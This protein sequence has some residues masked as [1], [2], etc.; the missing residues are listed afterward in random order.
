[1]AGEIGRWRNIYWHPITGMAVVVAAGAIVYSVAGDVT[2]M[3]A[4]S[5]TVCIVAVCALVGAAVGENVFI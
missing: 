1:M 5:L 3:E 2:A 4:P